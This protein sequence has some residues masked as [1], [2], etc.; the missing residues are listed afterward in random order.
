MLPMRFELTF[1]TEQDFKSC[2]Y[3]ISTTEAYPRWD[4]N[5]QSSRFWVVCV[6]QFRHSG[7][8]LSGWGFAPYMEPYSFNSIFTYQFEITADFIA[9]YGSVLSFDHLDK[10]LCNSVSIYYVSS[11]LI[12]LSVYLFRHQTTGIFGCLTTSLPW[13]RVAVLHSLSM[14]L[15]G[16]IEHIKRTRTVTIHTNRQPPS[17]IERR[18][19]KRMDSNHRNDFSFADFQDLCNKPLCHVCKWRE[20]ESNWPIRIMSPSS[21]HYFIPL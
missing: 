12:K 17:R 21:I 14:H 4:S 2:V 5:P 10:P 6:C 7:K 15:P 1:H 18:S 11:F 16:Y 20:S 13:C 19:R 8:K 3:A 9:S